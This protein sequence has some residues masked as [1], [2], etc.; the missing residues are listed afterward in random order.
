MCWG[1]QGGRQRERCV[2][3][4]NVVDRENDVLGRTRW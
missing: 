3:E 4:N 1:E 2:R